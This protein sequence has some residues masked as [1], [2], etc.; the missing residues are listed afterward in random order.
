MRSRPRTT[1]RGAYLLLKSPGDLAPYVADKNNGL[2]V[3]VVQIP[4]PEVP[5]E[6]PG[7]MPGMVPG[8]VPGMAPGMAPGQPMAPGMA[9]PPL[10]LW[11]RR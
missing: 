1:S 9:P 7:M 5:A 11:L 8:M 3:L 2:V 4:K 6:M 10:L